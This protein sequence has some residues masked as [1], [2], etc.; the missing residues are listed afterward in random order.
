MS[1]KE[2]HSVLTEKLWKT[3][4]KMYYSLELSINQTRML[5]IVSR[6]V[7][8]DFPK[9]LPQNVQRSIHVST[10]QMLSVINKA[11]GREES[12]VKR[13]KDKLKGLYDIKITKDMGSTIL[14]MSIALINL[15]IPLMEIESES[16]LYSQELVMI[17]AHLD[18]FMSDSL[19]IICQACP[20]VLK[21]NKKIDWATAISCGGWEK[22]LDHLIEKYVFEFGWQSISKRIKSL[23]EELGIIVK[24]RGS[25][26]ELLE[27]A[28][29]LRNIVVHNGGRVSQEYIAKTGRNDLI[30]GAF[31]P[32]KSK[33]L[34]K[35]SSAARVLCGELFMGIGRKFFNKKSPGDFTYIVHGGKSNK[36][37]SNALIVKL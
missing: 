4:S 30:V 3:Y 23:R 22:L 25:D 10:G 33:Y 34:G 14:F 32:L 21:R 11:L 15:G 18:A 37:K 29:E 13:T 26:L 8:K 19:R 1:T 27:E 2:E 12:V 36:K 7:F 9:G 20:E 35:V 5:T 31:Y 16:L 24:Y 28:E 17:F 6:E